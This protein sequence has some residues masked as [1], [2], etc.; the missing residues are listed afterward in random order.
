MK[1]SS[2]HDAAVYTTRI[3]A[4]HGLLRAAGAGGAILAPTD[5]MRYLSGWS[6]HGHERLI[7]LFVPASGEPTFLVPK[8]NAPQALTNPAGIQDVRGWED[9][10]GWAGL[11]TEVIAGWASSE[12]ILVDD[13]MQAGHLLQLQEALPAVR[14]RSVGPSLAVLR[15]RKS[16]GELDLMRRSAEI[17]DEVYSATIKE[18]EPGLSENEV[19]HIISLEYRVRDTLPSFSLVCF[20]PNTALP[21]HSS[22]DRR[23]ADGDVVILDIGCHWHGYASDITRTVAFRRADPNAAEVYRV[24]HRAHTAV[25]EFAKPGVTCESVDASARSVI[26][27]A[28][29]GENFVHRTGHGIGLSTHEPPYIVKGNPQKLEEGMCFSDEPGIYLPGRFGVRI[30]NIVTVT[31]SGVASLNAAPPTELEVVG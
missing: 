28:G 20:G 12:T 5:Q 4:L 18:L 11:A 23:L 6:E 13:E 21:H 7:A 10:T 27:S 15:E 8:M 24:V 30:E 17:T 2:E 31:G 16:H 19:Q 29:Y 26:E 14:W 3:A 25:M 1:P 22:G 9:E